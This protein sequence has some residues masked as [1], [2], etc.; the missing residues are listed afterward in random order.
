M[1]KGKI[2]IRIPEEISN[3]LLIDKLINY[4]NEKEEMS[5]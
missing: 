1:K 5:Q 2:V 3:Q 4:V